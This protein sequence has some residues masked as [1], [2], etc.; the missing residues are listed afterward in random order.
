MNPE[1]ESTHP[2]CEGEP[3][4]NPETEAR[5]KERMMRVAGGATQGETPP[6]REAKAKRHAKARAKS[7]RARTARRRS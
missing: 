4:D 7:K 1:N 3:W 5:F 2:A 6:K